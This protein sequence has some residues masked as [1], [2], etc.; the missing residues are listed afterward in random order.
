[1]YIT[2]LCVSVPTSN[3]AHSHSYLSA[4][5]VHSSNSHFVHVYSYCLAPTKMNQSHL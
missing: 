1:M 2:A 3:T 5:L 4:I